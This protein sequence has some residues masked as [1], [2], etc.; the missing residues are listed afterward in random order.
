MQVIEIGKTKVG[1]G[2]PF[3]LTSK[4][5]LA[6]TYSKQ[7]RWKEAEQLQV[8]VL[9]TSKTRLGADHAHTLIYMANLAF[10]WKSS[11]H[12]KAF[13]LLRDC[14]AKQQ[15][16]L[17]QNHPHTVSHSTLLLEWETEKLD[18]NGETS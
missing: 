12:A 7:G 4:A 14:L 18:M 6:L 3:T 8:Q 1:A 9:E 11:G 17:G 13:D 5:N 2:H 10:T 15:Q 16:I